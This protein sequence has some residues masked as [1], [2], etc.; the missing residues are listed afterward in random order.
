MIWRGSLRFGCVIPGCSWWWFSEPSLGNFLVLFSGP[1]S[2]WFDGGNLWEPFVVL[3][4]VIPL[5]NPWV[6]GLDIG[7]FGVL[8]LE[9]VLA[10]FLRFLLFGH[11][12]GGLNLAM[13]STWGVRIAPK[14]CSS[15]WSDSGDQGLDLEV[16]TYGC[17]S[18]R[19]AQVTPVWPVPL[20]G[21]TGASPIGFLLGWTS[22]CVRCCPVSQLFRVWVGLKLGWPVWCFGAFR[23]TPVWPVCCIGLTGVDPLC[24]SRQVSP[25]RTGLTGGAHQSNRCWSV[26]SRFGVPLRS[27]VGRLCVGS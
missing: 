17:C 18:S 27:R 24:G 7:V 22:G 25:A 26:D 2:W 1:C 3:W 8:G 15:L 5:K 13:D 19:E 9:V 6:N 11:V 23:L 20:I 12:L 10:G 21:L 14:S 16:L 4:A